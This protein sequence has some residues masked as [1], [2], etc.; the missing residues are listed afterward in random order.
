MQA[1]RA[2]VATATSTSQKYLQP[3]RFVRE[4]WWKPCAEV[5]RLN[6]EKRMS[7]LKTQDQKPLCLTHFQFSALFLSFLSSSLCSL[8][9][10]AGNRCCTEKMQG[11][12]MGKRESPQSERE[13]GVSDPG[14]F[15]LDRLQT[16]KLILFQKCFTFFTFYTGRSNSL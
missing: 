5:H 6:P 2:R 13:T 7:S 12:K 8:K 10:E 14:V 15:K 1:M 4:K 9:N 16:V 3:D 11:Q